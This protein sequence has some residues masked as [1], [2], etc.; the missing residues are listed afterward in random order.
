MPVQELPVWKE[1]QAHQRV[2]EPAHL[3]EMFAQD[4]QRFSRFSLEL[5]DLL[6]DYSKKQNR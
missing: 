4:P 2:C 5:G 3:R 6:V 1:L